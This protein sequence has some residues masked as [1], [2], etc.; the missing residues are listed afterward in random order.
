MTRQEFDR[1]GCLRWSELTPEESWQTDELILREC[2]DSGASGVHEKEFFRR[3]G[4]RAV[5]LVAATFLTSLQTEGVAFVVD[6]TDRKKLNRQFRGVAEAAVAISAAPSVNDVLLIVN[7]HVRSLV[8]CRRTEIRLSSEP[9]A[10]G[11]ADLVVPLKDRSGNVMGAV[12]LWAQEPGAFLENDR[13]VVV[14][15]AQMASIAIENTELNESL[16]QS[17][18]DLQRA[19]EDLNQFAYSASHD[20]QEPLRMVSIYTQLLGKRMGDAADAEIRDCM[21][22]TLDGAQRMEMLIRDLL[23]YTQA[24]NIR[25]IPE[26]P[27]DS[28]A[29]LAKAIANLQSAIDLSGADIHYGFMPVLRAYDIHLVQLFQNLVGNAIKYR[30]AERPQIDISVRHDDTAGCWVFTVQDNGIGISPRYHSQV[31]GLFKRLY[32]AHEYPGTGIGLA[33]CQKVVE[34]YGGRIW[35]ESEEGAGS[36]FIFTFPS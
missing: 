28:G 7:H 24:V 16:R 13:A 35:V 31:F 17:N 15:L 11:A 20:L 32:A 25:G 19:N 22:F 34:R 8:P 2:R 5:V 30:G 33:I 26:S 1:T 6:I 18:N 23:A 3:D 9:V 36:R 21:R 27:V 12:R 10:E 4:T 14:Q 29:S